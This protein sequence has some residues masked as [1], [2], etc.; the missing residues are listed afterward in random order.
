MEN[1]TFC[2]QL[3]EFQT[4]WGN[5]NVGVSRGAVLSPLLFGIYINDIPTLNIKNHSYS[6]LF[7]DNLITFYIY[8]KNTKMGK[9][10][11]K[12][13]TLI[14][15][16]LIKWRLRMNTKKCNSIVFSKSGHKAHQEKLKLFLFKDPIPKVSSVKFLGLHIDVGLTFH[17]HV[18]NI[19]KKCRNCLNVIK[20][21]SNKAW[22]LNPTH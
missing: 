20:I 15:N 6:L 3:N 16:W 13:L 1:R 17:E 7:A 21:L 18:I 22:K 4:D 2:V 5:I 8:K 10:I 14:E 9:E 12:Y 11:G 19:K